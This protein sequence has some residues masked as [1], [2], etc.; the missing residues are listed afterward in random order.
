M[1]SYSCASAYYTNNQ[2]SLYDL[3]R[4]C[5]DPDELRIFILKEELLG[6]RSGLRK[7]CKSGNVSIF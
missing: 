5:D 6:N 3:E 4:L 2:T 1:C 7:V